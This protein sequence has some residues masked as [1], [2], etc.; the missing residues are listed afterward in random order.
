MAGSTSGGNAQNRPTKNE[1][2]EA[3]REKA[4]Q[5][6]EQQERQ[7]KR[8]RLLIQIGVVVAVVAVVVGGWLIVQ[9][10]QKHEQAAASVMPANM[11]NDG[12]VISQDLAVQ[13]AEARSVDVQPERQTSADGRLVVELYADFMCPV[14][15]QFEQTYGQML[16]EQAQAGNIDL[17][18]HPVSILDQASQGTKYSTRAAAAAASVATYAPDSFLNYFTTLLQP[19]VQPSESTSGLT[20]DRLVELA[21]QVI[22]DDQP[23]EQDQVEKSIRDGEFKKWVKRSTDAAN[24][25]G[26]PTV[27]IDGQSVDDLSKVSETLQQ[28]LKDRGIDMTQTGAD[29]SSGQ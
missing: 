1:R 20:D 4:R 8:N 13:R 14:C 24:L 7:R 9:N 16:S 25:T 28:K 3:A 29:V 12:V 5:L 26:T 11:P 23:D 6:R 18:I 22:G 10:V 27:Y 2:R 17:V 19:G 21:R 15:G